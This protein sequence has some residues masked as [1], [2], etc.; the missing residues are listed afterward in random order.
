MSAT[1]LGNIASATS[2][3]RDSEGNESTSMTTESADSQ[4]ALL[5]V[6]AS[7]GVQFNSCV[8]VSTPI[9]TG[10]RYLRW[11]ESAGQ[12]IVP[13]TAD[14]DA[15]RRTI[16]AANIAAARYLVG[17]VRRSCDM[18][19]I[20]P[21]ELADITGW[22]QGDYHRYWIKVIERYVRKVV[23]ADGWQYSEGCAKEFAAAVESSVATVDREQS[24][25]SLESGLG[26]VREARCRY[27]SAGIP[28]PVL[29]DVAERLRSCL[30]DQIRVPVGA[31][32]H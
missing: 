25:I 18:S 16:K 29:N 31:A 15:A 27:Y 21:T 5:S 28:S 3:R 20:D 7:L 22:Q 12:Q 32:T 30:S 10:Q 2:D 13:G 19:V 23:F 4:Y 1:I 6:I 17:D 24:P 9:S 8:Y 11:R 14:Y 26:M